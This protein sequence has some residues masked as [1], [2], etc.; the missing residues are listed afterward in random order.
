MIK[1]NKKCLMYG[2][3]YMEMMPAIEPLTETRFYEV[4]EGKIIFAI[5]R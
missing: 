3:G 4:K 1:Q 2:Q 5:S